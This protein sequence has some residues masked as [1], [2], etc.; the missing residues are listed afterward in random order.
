MSRKQIKKDF[1][2]LYIGQNVEQ[3]VKKHYTK[4][5]REMFI[6]ILAGIAIFLVATIKEYREG[7]ISDNIIY[8]NENGEGK[9]EVLALL[10]QA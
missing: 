8:R 2:E 4:K 1:E 5:K 10:G 9:K 3:L 7:I 6:L